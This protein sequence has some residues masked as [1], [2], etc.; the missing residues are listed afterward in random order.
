MDHVGT[1]RE[2]DVVKSNR[3]HTDRFGNILITPPARLFIESM[4]A[5]MLDCLF[6]STSLVGQF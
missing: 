2:S 5:I 4:L 6:I 3:E 1:D